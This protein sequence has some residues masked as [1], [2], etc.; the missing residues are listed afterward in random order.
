MCPFLFAKKEN[1]YDMSKDKTPEIRKKEAEEAVNK[2]KQELEERKKKRDEAIKAVG[3][4]KGILT[5]E[6]PI[7]AGEK[8]IAELTYDFTTLTGL[9]YTEA[10]DSDVNATQI[11]KITY[12]QALAL[13][14]KAC[15]KY[16]EYLDARDIVERLGVTDAIEGVHLATLFFTASTRAGQMRISRKQ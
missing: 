3:E 9:E 4:G 14:A 5:L 7:K 11:Y 8:E 15:A 16:N 10:M 2:F 13:F 1:Q 12:R 6:T